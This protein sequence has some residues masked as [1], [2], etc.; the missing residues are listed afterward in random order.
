VNLSLEYSDQD[1][2]RL[3]AAKKTI[4]KL[5]KEIMTEKTKQRIIRLLIYVIVGF[6]VAFLWH[7]MKSNQ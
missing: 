3:V 4:E 5:G 6:A 7:Q 1:S 2:K